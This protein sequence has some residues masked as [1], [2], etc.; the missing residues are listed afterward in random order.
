MQADVAILPPLADLSMKS[1]FQRDP[2]PVFAY[3]KYVYQVWE[4]IHQNGNGCDYVTENI[5]QRAT[6]ANGVLTYGTRNYKTLMLIDVDSLLP[7]TAAA[8]KKFTDA[9]GKLICIEKV[10]TGLPPIK[11]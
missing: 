10:P 8:I 4:T 2:F 9:G 6:I 5:I 11:N 3:P 7:A 1:G